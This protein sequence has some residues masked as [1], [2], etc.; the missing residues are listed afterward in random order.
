MTEQPNDNEPKLQRRPVTLKDAKARKLMVQEDDYSYWKD[1]DKE[2]NANKGNA[3]AGARIVTKFHRGAYAKPPH[4]WQY[5]FNTADCLEAGF[6]GGCLPVHCF[7]WQAA[8][9][10]SNTIPVNVPKHGLVLARLDSLKLDVSDGK[11]KN[12]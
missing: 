2:G 1:L 4:K 5:K 3:S 9:E 10:Q 7:D 6:T 12:T 8:N 11:L